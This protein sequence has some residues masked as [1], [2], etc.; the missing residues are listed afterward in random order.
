MLVSETEAQRGHIA[1]L[2]QA[3]QEAAQE[4]EMLQ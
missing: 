4:N 2:E 3:L 1:K